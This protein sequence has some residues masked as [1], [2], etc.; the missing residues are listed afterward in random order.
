MR[1]LRKRRRGKENRGLKIIMIAII[2]A[3]G[4]LGILT[5][6]KTVAY[7]NDDETS[8]EN[9][10]SAGTLDFSLDSSG[11][12]ASRDVNI[13]NNGTLGFQY[14]VKTDN[15]SGKLCNY[16][17]LSADLEGTSVY[18]GPLSSFDYEAGEF[19]DLTDNWHFTTS[20]DSNDPDL[21]SNDPDLQDKTCSFDLVFDAVQIDGTGFSDQEIISNSIASNNWLP[22]VDLTYPVGGETWYIVPDSCSSIPACASWCE[23]HGM[24]ANCE[25]PITWTAT[26][27][28]GPH[29]DLLIDL[30]FSRDS[31]AS[32]LTQIAS[33]E[34]N[35][36]EFWWKIPYNTDYVT[37]H[38]R[39]KV[40]ATHK[41]YSSLWADDMSGDFC[42]PMLTLSD[43]LG[44]PEILEMPAPEIVDLPEISAIE[45]TTPEQ[46]N[47]EP[48]L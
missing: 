34:E 30:Y 36:G 44:I 23:N 26:N 47:E 5:I 29:S 43:I 27:Q 40:K 31:G 17:N 41:V 7:F 15:I 6:G 2:I 32:W 48:E 25:Y 20:L 21:D 16:L 10:Y 13:I 8:S 19:S 4:C 24:N 45:T 39:I 35:D 12:D 14:R 22:I 1:K 18:I 38:A 3:L 9:I 46:N 37:D 11:D 28:I 33:G 42:P